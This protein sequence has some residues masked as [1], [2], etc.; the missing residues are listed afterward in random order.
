MLCPLIDQIVTEKIYSLR[1]Q[2]RIQIKF[3]TDENSRTVSVLVQQ[4]EFQ[5]VLANLIGNAIDS[6][7]GSGLVHVKVV[8]STNWVKIQIQDNGKG[9]PPEFLLAL[10]Q[11]GMTFDKPGGS[12][13]GFFTPKLALNVGREKLKWSQNWV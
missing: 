7:R 10:G 8:G 5:R 6:I 13:L 1:D 11:K 3:N 9:I 4:N 12:G 2:N